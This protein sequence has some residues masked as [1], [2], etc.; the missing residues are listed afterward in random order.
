MNRP[1]EKELPT[2]LYI[3]G[4]WRDASDGGTFDVTNPA[5]EEV[6]ATVA[7]ATID[8]AMAALDA[9]EAAFAGWAARKPRERGEILRKAFEMI[10]ADSE[11]FARLITM[12]NGKALPDSRGE[13]AYAAEFFRWFS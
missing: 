5:T 4:E 3:G 1:A 6:I 11:R 10:V 8:D 13:I 9:A 7:G 12:E 2:K